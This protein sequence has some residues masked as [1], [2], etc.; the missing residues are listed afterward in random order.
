MRRDTVAIA[1]AI[2]RRVLLP[3]VFAGVA[4]TGKSAPPDE[5]RVHP[6]ALPSRTGRLQFRL[7]VEIMPV[8]LVPGA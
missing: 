2:R 5:H 3:P 1:V 6:I 7:T 8:L 4:K